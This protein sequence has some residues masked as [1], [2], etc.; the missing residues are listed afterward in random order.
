MRSE[1]GAVLILGAIALGGLA[2]T[3]CG[4]EGDASAGDVTTR[5]DPGSPDA[6]ATIDTQA[7]RER[8][9]LL[10]ELQAIDQALAPIREDALQ[11]PELK[12]HEQRVIERVEMAME[13][14]DPTLVGARTRFDSLRLELEAAQRA[15]DTAKGQELTGELQTLQS[16]LQQAQAEAVQEEEVSEAIEGFREALF[17]RMR[18]MDPRADSL[19]NL[20]ERLTER[21]EEAARAQ[22]PNEGR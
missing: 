22:N 19:L 15:Q 6:P 12:A 16:S 2:L 14:I 4:S 1:A 18:S 5:V 11:D 13:S 10:S 8:M 21:L 9:A 20:A 3:A 7:V 17:A